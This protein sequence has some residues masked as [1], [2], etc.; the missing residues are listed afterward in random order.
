MTE[1][2]LA[3]ADV[4]PWIALR[5]VRQGGVTWLG[6]QWL[7]GGREVPDYVADALTELRRQLLVTLADSEWGGCPRAV[8]TDA[9]VARFERLCQAGFGLSAEQYMAI[10]VSPVNVDRAAPR[11]AD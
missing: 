1:H 10:L 5:R 11:P 6:D 9:G 2:G 4:Y 3:G 8:L 7:D